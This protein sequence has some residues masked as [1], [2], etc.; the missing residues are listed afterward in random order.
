V[1]GGAGDGGLFLDHNIDWVA[2]AFGGLGDIYIEVHVQIHVEVHRFGLHKILALE[3]V[4]SIVL[5][6]ALG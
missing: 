3:G 5:G 2:F 6:V 1:T 4:L